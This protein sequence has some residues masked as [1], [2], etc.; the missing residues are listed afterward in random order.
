VVGA[1]HDRLGAVLSVVLTDAS[2]LDR[3]R[4]RAREYLAGAE[5]PRSWF[6]RPQLPLTEAGKVDR[7]RLAALAAVAHGMRRLS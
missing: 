6:H 7:G 1:P 2:D 4:A 5:R 3:V